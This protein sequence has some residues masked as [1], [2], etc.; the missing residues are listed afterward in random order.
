[1]PTN[2][3]CP[4][5]ATVFDVEDVLSSDLEQKFRQ[6]YEDQL[7]QDLTLLQEDRKKLEEG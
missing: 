4:K 7:Q 5:C 2:I 1:M 6:K 3:K